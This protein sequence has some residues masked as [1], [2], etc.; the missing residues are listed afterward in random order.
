[1]STPIN[2]GKRDKTGTVSHCDVN[3]GKLQTRLYRQLRAA[4][5]IIEILT[6]GPIAAIVFISTTFISFLTSCA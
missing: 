6:N 4:Q 3:S 1:M 2:D 5:G